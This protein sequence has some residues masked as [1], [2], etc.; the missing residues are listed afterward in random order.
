MVL[1]QVGFLLEGFLIDEHVRQILNELMLEK[2]R[3]EAGR[4]GSRTHNT[5]DE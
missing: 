3:L 2:R 1:A 4:G 5:R